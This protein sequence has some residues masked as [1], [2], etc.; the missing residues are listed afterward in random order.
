MLRFGFA[1]RA[2]NAHYR[3]EILCVNTLNPANDVTATAAAAAAR[4]SLTQRRR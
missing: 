1:P 4:L 3:N 2:V